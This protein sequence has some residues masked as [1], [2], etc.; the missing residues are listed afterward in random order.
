[1]LTRRFWLGGVGVL[2]RIPPESGCSVRLS[3]GGVGWWADGGV[4]ACCGVS[5]LCGWGVGVRVS[6]GGWAGVVVVGVVDSAMASLISS[7]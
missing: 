5:V 3:G 4:S 1:M 2:A 7:S 6:V